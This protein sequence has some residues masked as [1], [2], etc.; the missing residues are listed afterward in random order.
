MI[1]LSDKEILGCDISKHNGKVDFN[2]MV[3]SGIKFVI[4]RAG[5]GS[6]TQDSNFTTNIKGAIDAGLLVGV[7]WFMY[8]KD[9]ANAIKNAKK[10]KEVISKYK[11]SIK[12]GVW[13]DWEYDSDKNAGSLTSEVRS[14]FVEEFCKE[15]Q[16][17][18]DTVG[19][20]SNQDYIKSGKFTKELIAE[21]PLWFAK[22]SSS[23]G[24]YANRGKDGKPYMWQYTSGESGA[25]H[26][27][28]S[29]TID[30]NKGFF[31]VIDS[32]SQV[33]DPPKPVEK[34]VTTPVDTTK[35]YKVGDTVTFKGCLH[36]T[37]SRS[38]GIARAC[39]A[40]LAK[41]T[42]ISKGNPH[43]YHLKAVTGKG[44]TVYGW[45]N[46]VDI[47]DGTVAGSAVSKTYTVKKGDTLS[48]ISKKYGT[49]VDTL[50]SLNG[51]KNKNLISV[52]QIIKLP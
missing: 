29:S 49:T 27:V 42:A 37:S 10:C 25:S 35:D 26:G 38:N 6:S 33:P 8:A 1:K 47:S 32:V 18:Y 4:I 48:K 52:G 19:I 31:D 43:P 40:G 34:P 28:S 46:A 11:D 12:L 39:K 20:Y 13:A 44:S 50:V 2:E 5:Y 45:V 21:Y 23:M 24:T 41:V 9:V 16:K 7:Y 30:M 22:Y 15:L 3:N 14:Q 51:I 36:Y 17:E